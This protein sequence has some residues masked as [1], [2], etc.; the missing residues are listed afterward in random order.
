M[1]YTWAEYPDEILNKFMGMESIGTLVECLVD[2]TPERLLTQF[3]NTIRGL[4]INMSDDGFDLSAIGESLAAAA[5]EMAPVSLQPRSDDDTPT[6]VSVIVTAVGILIS[7]SISIGVHL[8]QQKRARRDA[9]A[10]ETRAA[11][12]ETRAE[13]RAA[14]AEARAAAAETRVT[15][16]NNCCSGTAKREYYRL[17][18]SVV[19]ILFKLLWNSV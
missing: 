17:V 7:S 8:L 13:A 4:F 12:A 19:Q 18:Q 3:T 10:A 14:A 6:W 9:A 5:A 1:S 16:T 11:A 2:R 15:N